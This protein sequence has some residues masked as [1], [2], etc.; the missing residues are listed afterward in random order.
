M[1]RVFLLHGIV[2]SGILLGATGPALG[3]EVWNKVV[4]N[5]IHYYMP[6][7]DAHNEYVELVN[8]G[9]TVAFLDG[10]VITDEGE[11][12][13]PEA[14]F[15][16]PGQHGGYEHPIWPD[17]IVLIA[18]DGVPGEIEPD[19]SNAD[20]EF[21]HPSDDNDNPDVPN[22]IHCA[23]SDI[24]IALANVGDGILLATGTDTTA[25]VDCS[26]IVDGVNWASV[27]DP[28]PITWTFCTDP[29]FAEGIPQGNSI[30]RCP[31]GID[32]NDSSAEDWFMMIPS[33]GET[34]IPS[35]PTDCWAS[36]T[37][38]QM[39]WGTIKGLYR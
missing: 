28:V 39:S 33:P 11:D 24:D 23:G 30:G 29:A 12:G 3:L 21:V 25:A 14:V 22:L 4:F 6:G 15:R 38:R 20:W 5:E 17:E 13:M 9:G 18:V 2:A 34:N 26:S 19:L 1:G 16:F 32:G 8:A 27:A 35:W 36:V 31:G 7:F 10:A 37:S